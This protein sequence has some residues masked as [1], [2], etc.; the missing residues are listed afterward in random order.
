MS[1]SYRKAEESINNV[2]KL[3]LSFLLFDSLK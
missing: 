3:I 2:I 1:L